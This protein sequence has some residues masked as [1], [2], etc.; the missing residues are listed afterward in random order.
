MRLI[1]GILFTILMAGCVNTTPKLNDMSKGT[2]AFELK[3]GFY[4]KETPMDWQYRNSPIEVPFVSNVE[5]R[6]LT[7][8]GIII[9]RE[10]WDTAQA[11][12]K[13]ISN[14]EK[15][16]YGSWQVI[17]CK[18]KNKDLNGTVQQSAGFDGDSFIY[19]KGFLLGKNCGLIEVI[20][21]K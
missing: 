19:N 16:K 15:T 7:V 21:E 3:E 2:F 18:T 11:K 14:N 9:F 13:M 4:I 10:E 5:D 1:L 17:N 20:N 8:F 6:N 12:V